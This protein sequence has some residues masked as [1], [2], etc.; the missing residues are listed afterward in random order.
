MN[1]KPILKLGA[2]RFSL[3]FSLCL[4][5]LDVAYA[6]GGGEESGNR[7]SAQPLIIPELPKT[8]PQITPAQEAPADSKR[9]KTTKKLQID[10]I[11]FSGNTV[12]P[13]SELDEL[14][15]PYT[16][17]VVSLDELEEL[18]RLV[19]RHYI[20]KGYVTSGATF[21]PNAVQGKTLQIKVI[22]GKLGEMRIE[23][24]EGL[25]EDYIKSRL[26]K[27]P[28]EPLNMQEL[29][30]RFRLLLTDPM[31]DHMNGK[32]IPGQE[33]GL[34]ILDLDIARAR[35]YQLSFQSNNYRTPSIGAEAMGGTGWVRNLTG[36]GDVID[37]NYMQSEGAQQFGGSVLMP[38]GHFGTKAYFM[39]SNGNSHIIDPALLRLNIRSETFS[40]EG[41]LS[42]MLIDNLD[43]R[44]SVSAGVGF[45]E[46][47]T[48]LFD[49]RSFS[50]ILGQRDGHTQVSFVRLNQEYIERWATQVLALR[51]TFSVGLDSFGAS[52]V[53]NS[54]YPSSDYFAWLG[55]GQYNVQLPYLMSGMNLAIKG[56]VQ[57]ANSPLMPLERIAVGGRYTIRGYRENQ[58][59]KDAGYSGSIELHAPL[60]A[61]SG[62]KSD[63]Q[64]DLVPFFD[65]GAAWNKR[66]AVGNSTKA[67]YLA[68][69]GIGFQF[70]LPHVNSEFYWAHPILKPPT[71]GHGDLQDA[72]VHFQV[73]LDAF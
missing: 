53:T 3:A 18:R 60:L 70:K 6:V 48:T 40:V 5:T 62:G 17:R 36:Q 14:A 1:Q 39:A 13:T 45:K 71:V 28:D 42:Q 57:L 61:E 44:L 69:T 47:D 52:Q 30:N 11:Q 7:P 49:G 2:K 26:I 31:F 54:R 41:G 68:S 73:R 8:A 23:G 22:E 55:Q 46:N 12:I 35:P 59:V 4:A 67:Y 32:L 10:T 37:F 33:R 63:Y 65:Y 15:K 64:F 19:T 58:L 50:F 56:N 21:P 72:G 20:S 25:T 66:D 29:Q 38:L 16:N 24:E 34:S 43:R 9:G 27:D 51:S